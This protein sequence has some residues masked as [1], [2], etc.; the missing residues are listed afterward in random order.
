[1]TFFHRVHPVEGRRMAFEAPVPPDM[2]ELIAALRTG[3]QALTV[4]CLSISPTA[5]RACLIT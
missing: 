3:A 2:M 5:P 4:T 1:M